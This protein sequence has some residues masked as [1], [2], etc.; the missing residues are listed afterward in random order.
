MNGGFY[1]E[2]KPAGQLHGVPVYRNKI[3][4]CEY[5][6]LSSTGKIP[7]IPLTREEYMTHCIGEIEKIVAEE[8][9]NGPQID[10][11]ALA[12]LPPEDR[13]TLEKLAADNVALKLAKQRL[14]RHQEVLAQM[15][16]QERAAQ[17][18]YG[19]LGDEDLFGPEL[20]LVGQEG[21]GYIKANPEWFDPS[22][23]RSDLQLM[24]VK[25]D[26][27]SM[28]P[29]HPAINAR[30]GDAC[31]LRLWETL[32]KLDWKAISQALPR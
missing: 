23:P 11:D 21:D 10:K 30:T 6:V 1:Y 19:H 13:A 32:H 29:D 24:I 16:P 22:R 7:W 31:D 3:N 12:L 4:S 28:D 27:S 14:K 9:K 15:S 17:A 2:R 25:F 8:T 18:R 26:Y 5:I 20:A